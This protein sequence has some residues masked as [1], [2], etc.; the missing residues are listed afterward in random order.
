M[1]LVPWQPVASPWVV[2]DQSSREAL[3]QNVCATVVRSPL[4]SSSGVFWLSLQVPATLCWLT[5]HTGTR[6]PLLPTCVHHVW[7]LLLAVGPVVCVWGH[8]QLSFGAL[9]SCS[10]GQSLWPLGLIRSGFPTCLSHSSSTGQQSPVSSAASRDSPGS[11]PVAHAVIWQKAPL[12][13]I[14]G[15]MSSTFSYWLLFLCT[16]C[17]FLVGSQ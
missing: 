2:C 14:S 10:T 3:T 12:G 7:T 17:I 6:L 8:W 15:Q 13:L 1:E 5:S 11:E 4:T 9:A 16:T